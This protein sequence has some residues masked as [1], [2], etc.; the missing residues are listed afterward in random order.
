MCWKYA[1]SKMYAACVELDFRPNSLRSLILR[2]TVSLEKS[3]VST[4]AAQ[5][6]R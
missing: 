2:Y 3:G 4:Q 1:P 5:I 6:K